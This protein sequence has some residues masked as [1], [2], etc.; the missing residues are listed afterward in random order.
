MVSDRVEVM[1]TLKTYRW[2]GGSD[3]RADGPADTLGYFGYM[4]EDSFRRTTGICGANL[5]PW[6]GSVLSFGVELEQEDQDSVSESL[7]QWGPSEGN[8]EYERWNRGYYAHLVSEVSGG[9]GISGSAW[10]TTNSTGV[11]SPIRR[12]VLFDPLFGTR[13][14]GSLGRGLKEPT[15]LETSS[16]GFSVGNPDL[17]P[18]RSQVWEIG[19][20]TG[21]GERGAR[22]FAD[23]V[24]AVPPGPDPVHLHPPDPGGPNYFN[25]AEARTQGIEATLTAPLGALTISGAY[26]YLDSEVLDAGFDEGEGAVFV[27]GDALIRRPRHQGSLSAALPVRPGG[28]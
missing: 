5:A 6:A 23:L 3:D 27:E 18:E 2:D 8:S 24:P 9:P 14:R 16:S 4:S 22:L 25:V 19:A 13:L 10:T 15:F 7:S 1:A 11:S 28:P 20:G 26:T 21:L 12:A 17:E